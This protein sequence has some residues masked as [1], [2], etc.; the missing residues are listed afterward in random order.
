MTQKSLLDG[1]KVLVVDDEQDVLDTLT[2]LLSMCEVSKALSFAE[3]K[4]LLDSSS[5]DLVILDIMGVEGFDLLKITTAKKITSVMLT[6][7][8]LSPE[9]VVRSYKGGAAYYLP[10]EEMVN[11]AS[12]LEEILTAIHQGMNPW[13]RWL[14]RLA[15]FCERTFGE[16]WQD[17]DKDF[18]DKFPFY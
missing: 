11:I 5:F 15:D 3:G 2:E 17:K 7:H 9:N 10:K 12:F 6:A 4:D 14:H 13:D 8:A 16:K 1:K 18:W